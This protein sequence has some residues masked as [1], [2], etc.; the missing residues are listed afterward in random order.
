MVLMVRTSERLMGFISSDRLQ[1][2]LLLIVVVVVGK[3]AGA[4]SGTD[5]HAWRSRAPMQVD[6]VFAAA[7]A[8]R[9]GLRRRR[10]DTSEVSPARGT[11]HGW[12]A[13][14]MTCLTFAW[15]SAP[16][17]ALTQ[18]A[19]EVVTTVLLLLGLR[20]MPRRIQLNECATQVTRR[21]GR[22][23]RATSHLPSPSEPEWPLWPWRS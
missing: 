1:A 17:L 9:C 7:L 22:A 6:V 13:G 19:V 2:Q 11:D 23:A 3:C 18:I 14:L 5:D 20:W 4:A 10:G 16:D 15:F 8:R 21:R 12:R